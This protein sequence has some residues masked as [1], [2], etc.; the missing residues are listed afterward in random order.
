MRE[1]LRIQTN[2]ILRE[3]T[4]VLIWLK[5]NK[6]YWLFV[7]PL[8]LRRV[9][10]LCTLILI[11]ELVSLNFQE[12]LEKQNVSPNNSN[13]CRENLYKILK[14]YHDKIVERMK[15]FKKILDKSR[16][17]LITRKILIN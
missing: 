17:T 6:H 12:N 8:M 1:T 9:I 10:F 11:L 7:G 5:V 3:L 4:Y 16:I 14:K 15:A 13:N 2:T